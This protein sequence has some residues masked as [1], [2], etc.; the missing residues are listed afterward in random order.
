MEPLSKHEQELKDRSE[1]IV[2]E[3]AGLVN[4]MS[5]KPDYFIEKMSRDHRTL[6]QSFT[7]LCLQWLEYVGSVD[8][9]Y[10]GRNEASFNTANDIIVAF[11][12]THEC[13]P[14]QMLPLI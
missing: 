1:K 6:Q 11:R 2:E 7:K 9:R 10:D 13:S 8:Y 3:L 12:S 5:F 14:S 4:S